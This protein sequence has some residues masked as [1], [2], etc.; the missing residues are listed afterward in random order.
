MTQANPERDATI[1]REL[2]LADVVGSDVDPFGPL[3]IVEFENPALGARAIYVSHNVSRGP[4]IGGC[5][6]APDVTPREVY[7]LARAMTWKNAAALIPHG[8]A[9]SAIVANPADF[10]QG[11]DR[12]RELVEWYAACVQPYPEYIPGPDMSTDERDMDVIFER[13]RRAIG[14]TGGIPLDTLGLTALGVMQSFRLLVEGGFVS[15]LESVEGATMAVEG[16]G[17]V[18]AALARF[19]AQDGV[20]LVAVSDLVNPESDYGGVVYHA[21]GLDLE[22]L[23]ALREAGMSVVDTDQPGVE[24]FRGRGELKR[25]FAFPVDVTVPA[26]RTNSVDLEL[27]RHMQTK[28]ILEAAN[29]PLTDEAERHMHER[30]VLVGVDYI[31]NCGGVIGGAEGCAEWTKPLG[32]LRIPSCVARIVNAVTKNIPAIYGLARERGITPREAAAEIVRPRIA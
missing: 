21:E 18:G 20:K 28:L 12:R 25:I 32:A 19:A 30:G 4:A 17:N 9:K 10:P 29:A 27:A 16:F 1:G 8:G 31:V 2:D 15:G 5:R 7:E 24:V 3:K 11:S 22:R 23:L 26:A 13:N 6:F 14:R